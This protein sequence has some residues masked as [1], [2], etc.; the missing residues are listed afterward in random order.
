MQRPLAA[1]RPTLAAARRTLATAVRLT[2]AEVVVPVGVAAAAGLALAATI[3]PR[4][5]APGMPYFLGYGK[6]VE[7]AAVA[8]ALAAGAATQ[9][10]VRSRRGLAAC[11]LVAVTG[12]ALAAAVSPVA[13][14][15]DGWPQLLG[16]AGLATVIGLG[17]RGGGAA[18]EPPVERSPRSSCGTRRRAPPPTSSSDG[19]ATAPR[20]AA[21]RRLG[22]GGPRWRLLAAGRRAVTGRLR[23]GTVRGGRLRSPRS[24]ERGRSS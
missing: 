16:V 24:R 3:V 2:L 5:R 19:A 1:V 11:L 4:W 22:A 7:A 21:T 12:L 10:F 6:N 13:P 20:G 9:W 23:G 14:L 15:L 18:A 17:R 8:G